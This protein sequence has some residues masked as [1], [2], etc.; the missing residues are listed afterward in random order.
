MEACCRASQ[1]SWCLVQELHLHH[2][3]GEGKAGQTCGP[4]SE[5]AGA[6]GA[7]SLPAPPL[8]R[9]TAASAGPPQVQQAA[10]VNQACTPTVTTQHLAHL[11]RGDALQDQLRHAVAALH[12]GRRRTRQAWVIGYWWP[13][14]R[15]HI[16]QRAIATITRSKG[17]LASTECGEQQRSPVRPACR[18]A[19]ASPA[20]PPT[21]E[22]RVGMVEQHHPHLAAVVLIHHTRACR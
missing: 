11:G 9:V 6:L 20:C 14:R 8:G 21:G 7:P 5:Q 17:L 2:L 10:P 19:L 12:C 18:T 13:G 1:S 16:K 22:G 3:W 4:V 15:A